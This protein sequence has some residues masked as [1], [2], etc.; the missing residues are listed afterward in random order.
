MPKA[1]LVKRFLAALIDG[2]IMAIPSFIPVLGAIVGTAYALTKDAVVFEVTKN[3]EFRNRSIGKKVMNLEVTLLEGENYVDWATSIKRNLPL[4]IGVLIMII[5]IIGWVIGPII[6]LIIGL[7][8]CIFVLTDSQGRRMGD[9]YAN[10]QVV[11]AESSI[12]TP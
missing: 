8:E 3:E 1:D 10:T 11:E 12:E 9:K 2:L 4:S 5:P 6:G 7:I